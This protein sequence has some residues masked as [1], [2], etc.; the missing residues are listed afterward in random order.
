MSYDG[1]SFPGFA[2]SGAL[3]GTAEHVVMYPVDTLKT[4]MQALGQ[5]GQNLQLPVLRAFRSVLRME[6]I[7]GLYRGVPAVALSAGPAHAVYFATYELAKEFLGGNVDK[8]APGA[9]GFAGA[10]ATIGS[11]AIFTPA[12]VVK[13]RL[14]LAHSPYKGVFDCVIRTFREE[15]IRAFFRS[16]PTTLVMNVPFTAVHFSVYESAKRF[17]NN[18]DVENEGFSTQLA[19]GGLSGA[20][21]AAV[22]T[23]LDVVKTRLQ[24]QGVLNSQKYNTVSI[25]AMLRKLYAEEGFAGLTRGIRP[26]ILF[27]APSAAICWTTYETGKIFFCAG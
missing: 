2:L 24:T 23:P 14:Q 20:S 15:G 17:M 6:G 1:M 18:G 4:R 27:H 12:D 7:A 10:I 22:T 19:A 13:Q 21:A 3:A 25:L 11:D 26:R 5:P 16:L 8:Y 9:I